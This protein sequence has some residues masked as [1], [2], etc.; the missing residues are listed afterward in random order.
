MIMF[1]QEFCR[2]CARNS[3]NIIVMSLLAGNASISAENVQDFF[4]NSVIIPAG[5][6]QGFLE[7]FTTSY[8]SCR[9]C[10]VSM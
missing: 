8:L 7:L 3:C 1:L 2:N 5:N 6:V 10:S 9:N 4:Q